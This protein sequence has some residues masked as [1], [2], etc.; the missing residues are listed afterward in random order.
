M[1]GEPRLETSAA[2]F[3]NEQKIGLGLLLIFALVSVS[4]GM[5]QI[6]NRL[7]KPFALNN[8]VPGGLLEEVNTIEA[9]RFRDTDFDG[10]NDFDEMY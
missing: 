8:S 2:K 3:S 5:L 7:Y 4:L 9:L 1:A 6:R 10:L